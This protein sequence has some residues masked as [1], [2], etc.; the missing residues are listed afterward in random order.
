[1]VLVKSASS[2]SLSAETSVADLPISTSGQ[3]GASNSQPCAVDTALVQ[4]PRARCSV[5]IQT[6]PPL[7]AEA[8]Q[9]VVCRVSS[10]GAQMTPE[11][12]I[13]AQ[14]QML[15]VLLHALKCERRTCQ[16]SSE[17]QASVLSLLTQ[18]L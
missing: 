12:K 3:I 4:T 2:S 15:L 17:Q 1:M 8:S 16:E 10:H 13:F 9:S 7:S 5:S 11:I 14:Q 18:I 6:D